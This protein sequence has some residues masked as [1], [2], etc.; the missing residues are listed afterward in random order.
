MLQKEKQKETTVSGKSVI[1][2][3][4]ISMFKGG[5]HIC[6]RLELIIITKSHYCLPTLSTFSYKTAIF[7]FLF[8]IKGKRRKQKPS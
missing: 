1:R 7:I 5:S 3:D 2:T 8:G 6:K 4:L